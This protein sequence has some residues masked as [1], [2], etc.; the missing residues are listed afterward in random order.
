LLERKATRLVADDP[1]YLDLVRMQMSFVDQ[2]RRIYTLAKRIAK[3]ALPPGIAQ[4]D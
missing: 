2:M 1:D 3:V 4:K